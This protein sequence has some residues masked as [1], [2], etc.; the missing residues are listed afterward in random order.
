MNFLKNR[1]SKAVLGAF[2]ISA[3]LQGCGS[4][5]SSGECCQGE[6]KLADKIKEVDK[7]VAVPEVKGN[8]I[9]YVDRNVTVIQYVDRNVTIIQYVDRNV[10][11]DTIKIRPEARISGL[12]D[13]VV[14]KDATLLKIDSLNSSDE[15]GNVTKYQWML[16][17]VAISTEKSPEITLPTD[18]GS[19]ELCLLV[20]DNDDLISTKTCK[21]FVIPEANANPT[22]AMAKTRNG[23]EIGSNE[24]KTKCPIVFSGENSF[25]DNGNIVSY[26]WTVDGN[27]TY[28]GKDQEL[29]F[30]TLGEH[31]VCLTVVDS[32]DLNATRCDTIDVQDHDAPTPEIT[33][34]DINDNNKV[35][36]TTLPS[37]DKL[38]RGDRYDF[39][40]EGSK[41][42]CGNEE[43]MTCEWN[44]HSYREDANGNKVDYVRDCINH[45]NAPRVGKESWVKLC[46]S[47]ISSYKYIEIE[48]KITDQFGKSTTRTDIFE[49]AP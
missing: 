11:V 49:V 45:N 42:D 3:M 1:F 34:I 14:L 20:T 12:V 31:E 40:C 9:V 17:D 33:V 43:P 48:L 38:T 27:Q 30:D 2:A 16:D 46:G 26:I 41:D 5:S 10:T 37:G 15:D 47:S 35:F 4:S 22:A 28:I 44:V 25:K 19:Y 36:T 21:S 13:G 24:I 6:P 29:S 18:P 7:V 32:D 39:S 8:Q 23:E